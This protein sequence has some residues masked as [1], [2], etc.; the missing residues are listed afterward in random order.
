MADITWTHVT[1]FASELTGVDA[2]AQ[3]DI[4][5]FVNTEL[6]A[7]ECGGESSARYKMMRVYLAAHLAT[8]TTGGSAASAAGPVISE[9]AGDLSVGYAQ[10]ASSGD[11]DVLLDSTSYGKM[12]RMLLRTSPARAWRVL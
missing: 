7:T 12:Y 8:L 9:K 6:D 11:W 1:N 2:A 10:L 4:L 5:S 3:T